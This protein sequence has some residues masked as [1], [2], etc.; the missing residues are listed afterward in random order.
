MREEE[1]V[2]NSSTTAST[3]TALPPPPPPPPTLQCI[4]F[5]ASA[6]YLLLK[7]FTQECVFLFLQCLDW[8]SAISVGASPSPLSRNVHSP[9]T[10]TSTGTHKVAGPLLIWWRR[11]HLGR[12]GGQQTLCNTHTWH[13]AHC[14]IVSILGN[15]YG[16]L[17]KSDNTHDKTGLDGHVILVNVVRSPRRIAFLSIGEFL[18]GLFGWLF[19]KIPLYLF[20]GILRGGK[21]A[22]S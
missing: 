22:E 14:L 20:W 10:R 12:E 17:Y 4:G 5:S 21:N 18:F 13:F 19:A 8:G 1:E 16:N 3:S 6:N 7:E 9:P 2:C 11:C 15:L